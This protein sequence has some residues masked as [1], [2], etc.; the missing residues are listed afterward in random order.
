MKVHGIVTYNDISSLKDNILLVVM[1]RIL[2]FLPKKL[3][4]LAARLMV[5]EGQPIPVVENRKLVGI[6]HVKKLKACC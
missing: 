3:L 4:L 6:L 2:L 1:Y 5:W